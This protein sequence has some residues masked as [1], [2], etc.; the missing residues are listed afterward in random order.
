[1]IVDLGDAR[2]SGLA[3]KMVK[4]ERDRF[5]LISYL[6]LTAQKLYYIQVQLQIRNKSFLLYF[7][8]SQTRI[9]FQ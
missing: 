5:S 4:T 8:I 2:S 3:N 6:F 1:M 9:L 7:E